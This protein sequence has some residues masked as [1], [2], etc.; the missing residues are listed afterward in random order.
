MYDGGIKSV[1]N[2]PAEIELLFNNKSL[3]IVKF[4]TYMYV[5]KGRRKYVK[6]EEYVYY[7]M[8][9]ALEYENLKVNENLRYKYFKINTL[10]REIII[11]LEH[12]KYISISSEKASTIYE[13]LINV[14][15]KGKRILLDL[16]SKYF[17]ELRE[18]INNMKS[19]KPYS[20]SSYKIILE[21][22]N[23]WN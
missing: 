1:N 14:E 23:E 9:H 3:E 21:V 18:E 16:Q 8:V 7:E 19:N 2:I 4:L 6:I 17:I 20:K 11:Y 13:L 22:L 12:C 15:D 5:L 10:I